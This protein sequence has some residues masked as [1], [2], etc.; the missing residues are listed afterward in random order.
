MSGEKRANIS[1]N[2][3]AEPL[4]LSTAFAAPASGKLSPALTASQ[5]K[6]NLLKGFSL[7]END[8][9]LSKFEDLTLDDPPSPSAIALSKKRSRPAVELG[10]NHFPSMTKGTK[11]NNKVK[12][13]DKSWSS[14]GASD[15]PVSKTVSPKNPRSSNVDKATSS[16][17]EEIGPETLP[18]IASQ[19]NGEAGDVTDSS[20]CS[21]IQSSP[22]SEKHC[23][24]ESALSAFRTTHRRSVSMH[25]TRDGGSEPQSVSPATIVPESTHT[26]EPTTSS[27]THKLRRCSTG[28]L[29]AVGGKST[30]TIEPLSL[31]DEEP[32]HEITLPEPPKRSRASGR[33]SSRVRGQ[34]VQNTEQEFPDLE[35]FH[36]SK[37]DQE[38]LKPKILEA[39]QGKRISKLAHLR[40]IRHRLDNIW[41]AWSDT[42]A[43]LP[44]DPTSEDDGYIYIFRSKANIFPG[45]RY[46]KIGRTKQIPEKRRRQWELKCK[47]EAIQVQD[48]KDKRFVH[49]R[50]VER[51]VHAELYNE[52]R[53]Y[54]C[55]ECNKFHSLELGEGSSRSTPTEHGEWFE[56]SEEQALQVVNKWRDW[57]ID[58]EPYRP[59]GML[60]SRWVWKCAANSFWMKGTE[61]DW[62]AWRIFHWSENLRCLWH[63]LKQRAGRVL[64]LVMEILMTPETIFGLALVWYFSTWGFNVGSCVTILAAVFVLGYLSLELH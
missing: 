9:L 2:G 16:S 47:F 17:S 26:C 34:K 10:N 23:N 27:K 31:G 15:M 32:G 63:H 48:S 22:T 39:I 52:R 46:V 3:I 21:H 1:E 13:G 45:R 30:S 51:I 29:D 25:T 44:R 42:S 41:K 11:L 6:V 64:P 18:F 35:A 14:E 53:L 5:T 28:S 59:D 4:K 37:L 19:I 36:S 57:V 33:E 60:R 40:A 49:Y 61:E 54:R 58:N 56:I 8:E 24:E 20:G 62:A 50:A 43:R 38:S 12:D 55:N 7:P